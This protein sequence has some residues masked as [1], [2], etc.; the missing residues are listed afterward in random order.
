MK[1]SIPFFHTLDFI[2]QKHMAKQK[3]EKVI[4]SVELKD[5]NQVIE[6]R[7]GMSVSKENL[8]VER[9]EALVALNPSF[10]EFFNVKLT[11]KKDEQINDQVGS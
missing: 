10:K 11:N 9:Y 3:A 1:V 6:T 5:P 8:T 7:N 4:E 2:K